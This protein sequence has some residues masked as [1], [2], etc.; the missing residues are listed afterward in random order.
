MKTNM[1][2]DMFIILHAHK[3]THSE[4][5]FKLHRQL[6]GESEQA[7]STVIQRKALNV[8]DVQKQTLV[9]SPTP[10]QLLPKVY[11]WNLRFFLF[12]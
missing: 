5:F 11:K 4:T 3:S 8:K 2:G 7:T 10:Q 9:L 6:W 12:I 1:L